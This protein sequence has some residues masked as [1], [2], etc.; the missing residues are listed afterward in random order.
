MLDMPGCSS[1][2]K[3]IIY[4][5]GHGHANEVVEVDNGYLMGGKWTHIQ[6]FYFG[7][8]TCFPLHVDSHMTP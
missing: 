8:A 6:S 5:D 7:A 1:F 4:F 2:G 3:R